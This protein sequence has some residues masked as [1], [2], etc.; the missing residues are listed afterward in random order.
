[1]FNH[2]DLCT[3]MHMLKQAGHTAVT[4]Q[5]SVG[6]TWA[7]TDFRSIF[8]LLWLLNHSCKQL[9]QA[10]QFYGNCCTWA[11][12][13]NGSSH[14]LLALF[15]SGHVTYECILVNKKNIQ[16]MMACERTC[17][18]NYI[19]YAHKDLRDFSWGNP[20]CSITRANYAVAFQHV[21]RHE[22]F[23][24]FLFL[25]LV[26]HVLQ[27]PAVGSPLNQTPELIMISIRWIER[28]VA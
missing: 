14:Y 3:E 4:A 11:L 25:N 24:I 22:W 6:F 17:T 20:F 10:E 5:T 27:V 18:A 12:C 7:A 28:V 1:M 19:V 26:T 9:T 15:A 16:L 21:F 2:S 23:S 8:P 13:I